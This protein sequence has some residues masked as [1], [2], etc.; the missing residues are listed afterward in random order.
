MTSFTCKENSAILHGEVLFVCACFVILVPPVQ[1]FIRMI[2]RET[3]AIEFFFLGA[4]CAVRWRTQHGWVLCAGVHSLGWVLV[5]SGL[6]HTAMGRRSQ[7]QTCAVCTLAC[8]YHDAAIHIRAL[9]PAPAYG[10]GCYS[11]ACARRGV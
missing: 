8:D 2:V 10:A 11:H 4:V 6:Q 9:I 3:H 7:T 5:W 1:L